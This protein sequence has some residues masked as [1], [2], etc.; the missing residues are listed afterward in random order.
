MS[1]EETTENSGLDRR[2]RSS[3]DNGRTKIGVFMNHTVTRQLKPI[4]KMH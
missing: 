2:L 3:S 1:L 4:L